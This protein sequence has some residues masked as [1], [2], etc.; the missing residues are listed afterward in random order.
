MSR[1]L[2][3]NVA[4]LIHKVSAGPVLADT[5]FQLAPWDSGMLFPVSAYGT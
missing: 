5:Q 4:A 1:I 3:L 2:R